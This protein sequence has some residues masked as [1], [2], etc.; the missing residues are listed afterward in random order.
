MEDAP[1]AFRLSHLRIKNFRSV[2]EASI[3]FG[4]LSVLVGPNG[5]GKSNVVDALRFLRDCF[6]RGLDQAILDREGFT[7]LRHWSS[8]SIRHKISLGL[9]MSTDAN[10]SVDYDFTLGPHKQTGFIVTQEELYIQANEEPVRII[11]R[12][13]KRIITWRNKKHYLKS[14]PNDEVGIDNQLLGP[15]FLLRAFF[16][17]LEE[18]PDDESLPVDGTL[19]LGYQPLAYAMRQF[20]RNTLVYSLN[21]AELRAPQ[22]VMRG[23][24]FDEN[25]ENLSAVLRD[26][27][28]N[29]RLA[30]DIRQIL[31]R[32]VTG[33]VDFSISSTGSYLVTYLH[34]KDKTGKIRKADLGQESDGTLRVLG[35]LA[36][37]YQ[38]AELLLHRDDMHQLLVIEEPEVNIHPGILALLA[39]LFR[40]ASQR[41][42]ILLTTHS[43]DLLDFLP[44]ESFLVVDKQDG[45]T[46]IGPMSEEQV[47][48]VQKRLFTSGELFRVEGLHR[49]D[50]V[51]PT[52]I[53]SSE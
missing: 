50:P 27:S 43:P 6:S 48:I 4:P 3:S 40:E 51:P 18:N 17:L 9:T 52:T 26:L 34:Y 32:L 30:D 36:A 33:I 39:D 45:E 31:A 8:G 29:K 24:P 11:R 10:D 14:I 41:Y 2:G 5:S 7:V 25:G 13:G 38:R 46:R 37:L 47:Q 21:P 12:G 22:R 35:I 28:H 44:P 42:Q 16:Q 15:T 1:N 20:L 49:Q 19:V 53:V 23:T